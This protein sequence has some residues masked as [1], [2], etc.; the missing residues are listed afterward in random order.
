M[1]EEVCPTGIAGLD[2]VLG[3]GFP[4]G[5]IVLV[6]G[7]PGAGKTTMAA[8]FIYE[9]LRRGEPGV[10]LSFMESKHDFIKFM[11][12][13]GMDFTPYLRDGSFR[14]I[15]GIQ[16]TSFEGAKENLMEFLKAISDVGAKRVAMDSVTA[17]TQ[18]TTLRGARELIKNALVVG[19]RPYNVTG[20]VVAEL[21]IGYEIVGYG[22]EEFI[23]DG[24][25]ILKSEFRN[26]ILRRTLQVRKMR[27]TSIPEVELHYDIVTGEGIRVYVPV[28][29]EERGSLK[30][31]Y[32]TPLKPFDTLFGSVRRGSQILLYVDKF[33]PSLA[34]GVL[35]GL[36]FV[37]SSGGKLIIRSFSKPPAIVHH[38]IDILTD[39]LP[40]HRDD[41][42]VIVECLN[43]TQE[44]L[45]RIAHRSRDLES[46][47][48]PDYVVIDPLSQIVRLSGDMNDFYR[49]HINNLLLRRKLGITSFYTY[50]DDGNP[51]NKPPLELYDLTIVVRGEWVGRRRC[52]VAEPHGIA[53]DALGRPLKLCIEGRLFKLTLREDEV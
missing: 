32:V 10:Y 37:H 50:I 44:P 9:G 19:L 28:R 40:S 53:A 4:K 30:N 21:P 6:A 1:K 31:S 20:I 48:K 41:A 24:V 22:L 36:A 43:P 23:F 3:G 45:Y 29:V 51:G 18:M 27:G 52:F 34:V 13:L 16:S 39:V 33:T 8:R 12:L 17:I 35:A 15:E 2:E 46:S 7:T 42:E 5:S 38:V 47:L 11:K 14:F 26:G 25:I 49:D